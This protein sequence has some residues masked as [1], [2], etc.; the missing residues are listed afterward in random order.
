MANKRSL[1]AFALGAA[2]GAGAAYYLN[3]K[4]GKKLRK[5]LSKQMATL[6]D[7]VITSIQSQTENF[8]NRLSEM[9][10]HTKD[11]VEKAGTV[12]E[13][14]VHTAVDKSETFID[15]THSSFE[16]GRK[17]AQKAM[18]NKSAQLKEAIKKN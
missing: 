12:A 16:S 7:D 6:S 9:K 11:L 8:S 4:E 5:K 3:T 10:D 15:N 2:A 1:M 18:E 13:D 17:R 14:A